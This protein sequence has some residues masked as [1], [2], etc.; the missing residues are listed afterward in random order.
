MNF[1]LAW[2]SKMLTQV[3]LDRGCWRKKYPK[4][5][6]LLYRELQTP[7]STTSDNF[8][9]HIL[10]L[11][12]PAVDIRYPRWRTKTCPAHPPS[13]NLHIFWLVSTL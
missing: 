9:I 6:L 8:I 12:S 1:V 3:S 13:F 2:M 5:S 4:Q 7:S 10:I 11:F